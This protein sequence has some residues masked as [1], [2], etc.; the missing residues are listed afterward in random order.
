MHVYYRK[1]TLVFPP[2]FKQVRQAVY[3]IQ[4]AHG[5]THI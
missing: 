5:D 1:Y 3:E 4:V 2:L